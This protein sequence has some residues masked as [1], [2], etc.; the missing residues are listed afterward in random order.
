MTV[1][2]L[3]SRIDDDRQNANLSSAIRV[4][5]LQHVR[6]RVNAPQEQ[7]PLPAAQRAQPRPTSPRG[8]TIDR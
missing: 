1:S 7:P 8:L 2:K 5:V 4:F 3:V 6:D